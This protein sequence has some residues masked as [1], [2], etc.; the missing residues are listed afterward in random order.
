MRDFIGSHCLGL[1]LC[2][3]WLLSAGASAQK[4]KVEYN[5]DTDFQK[6]KT[7][8]W[9]EREQYLRPLL[10]AVVVGATDTQMQ[11]KGLT[12]VERNGD[13]VVSAYGAL[14]TDMSIAA[15]PSVI[16]YF[17]PVYGYPWWGSAM[18][19]PGSST[20]IYIPKGTLVLDLAD[21]HA[22]QL[23]WRGV[24]KCELNPQN[25][26]KSL[27]TIEKSIEKMFKKYPSQIAKQK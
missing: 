18:Y 6:Y 9:E 13:L 8:S 24:A 1:G 25:K 21:P 10:A 5:K 26:E 17:P 16:Y 4:V 14:D 12:K 20:A 2:V 11:A 22:K 19:M 23:R 7:Y 15:M 3:V 27:Q